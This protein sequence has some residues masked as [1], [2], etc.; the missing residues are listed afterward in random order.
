MPSNVLIAY[1]SNGQSI[2]VTLAS[3]ADGSARASTALDNSSDT[4]IDVLV[5]L[6][7]KT[8]ASGVSSAGYVNVYAYGSVDGGTTYTETASGT[9]AA[10]TLTV[11]T[12][13]K[14]VG[15][16]SAVANATTY[17]SGP[18]SVAGAFGGSLPEFWGIVIENK[19][20]AGLDS[21]E[22]NHSKKYQGVYSQ[23]N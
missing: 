14:L 22:G 5:S 19:T 13:L 7:L 12:N 15:R 21:T 9:D 2:T 18:F 1:G 6:S 3:L 17:K 4:F 8:G 16:I 23:V 10:L 11:P 20:G